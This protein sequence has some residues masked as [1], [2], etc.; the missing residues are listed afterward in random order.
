MPDTISAAVSPTR[1]P[2]AVAEAAAVAMRLARPYWLADP[3]IGRL[4]GTAVEP[5]TGAL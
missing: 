2:D 3:T 4:A 1:W 5:T